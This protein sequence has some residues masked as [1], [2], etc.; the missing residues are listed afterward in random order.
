M[1]T[2]S[3]RSTPSTPGSGVEPANASGDREVIS[4]SCVRP[5]GARPPLCPG[6]TTSE[7]SAE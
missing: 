4:T 3:I 1:T 5:S 7:A 6:S 2:T